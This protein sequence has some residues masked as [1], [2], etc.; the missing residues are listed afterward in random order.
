[1][2]ENTAKRVKL[3][4]PQVKAT[5]SELHSAA[6]EVIDVDVDVDE[7]NT[8]PAADH[9]YVDLDSFSLTETL[10]KTWRSAVYTFFKL[11]AV[12]VQYHNGHLVHFFPCGA[13]K[14]KLSVGGV[15]CFQDSKDK[16]STTNL[17]HHTNGCWGKEAVDRAFSGGKVQATSGSVFSAFARKGQQPVHHTYR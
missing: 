11:D 7:N 9:V 13:H 17:R 1:M 12:A 14:C 16:S 15:R 6:P 8:A 3:I 10:K 4:I 2:A 5:P